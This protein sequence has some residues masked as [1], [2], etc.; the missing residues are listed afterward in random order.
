MPQH[1]GAEPK[2]KKSEG[3][4][5]QKQASSVLWLVRI[6]RTVVDIHVAGN[7]CTEAVAY[8]VVYR[9]VELAVSTYWHVFTSFSG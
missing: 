7:L 5:P 8:S 4:A 2:I 3:S 1:D 6:C 9:L